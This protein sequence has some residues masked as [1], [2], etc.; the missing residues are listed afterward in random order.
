[1][2]QTQYGK[3]PKYFEGSNFDFLIS[4]T[5]EDLSAKEI[6]T[7]V[8]D[9]S[10]SLNNSLQGSFDKSIL[11]WSFKVHKIDEFWSYLFLF[12]MMWH[13]VSSVTR[14]GEISPLLQNFKVLSICAILGPIF[15]DWN[16]QII[17][18]NLAIWSHWLSVMWCV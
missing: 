5:K 14:F 7:I 15:S 6:R 8:S 9:L 16:D 3:G 4:V 2:Q 18:N 17:K 1:M 10:F 12:V 13:I 11:E